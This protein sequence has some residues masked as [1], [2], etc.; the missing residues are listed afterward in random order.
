MSLDVAPTVAAL[1]SARRESAT[2]TT[3][4]MTFAVFHEDG[5]IAGWIEERTRALAGKHP[6]RVVIFDALHDPTDQ[7]ISPGDVRGEW[8]EVGARG[9]NAAELATALSLLELPGAPVV[10][11]WAGGALASDER[12]LALARLANATIC[13]SSLTRT[14]GEGLRDLT[15]FVEAHPEIVLHDVS[16]LRLAS[17]QEII[18]EFFDEPARAGDLA[19][20][21]SVEVGAGSD[22]EMYYLLGWLASRLAW[23]PKERSRFSS[24]GGPVDYAMQHVGPP[25]RLSRVELRTQDARYTAF[26][27]P[28]DEATICLETATGASAIRRCAP[29]HSVDLASLVERAILERRRDDVFIESMTMA[30]H[31]LD[32]QAA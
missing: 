32:R 30:R 4:T 10:L 14:D 2:T 6:S 28:Q 19:R 24:P 27:H 16:Y 11:F 12:A 18:A 3:S 1:A 22:A 8:V 7:R 23:T 17:W 20:I 9:A 13:S 25:R 5:Q 29:L 31:I 26:I 15:V 21:R